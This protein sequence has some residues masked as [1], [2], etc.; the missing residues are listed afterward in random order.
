MDMFM[1]FNFNMIF[2]Y[3]RKKENIILIIKTKIWIVIKKENSIV[4][5]NF[6][7]LLAILIVSNFFCLHDYW[8]TFK[9]Y[10]GHF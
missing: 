3:E 4:K 1:T 2:Y 7:L 8:R 10:L 5:N 9:E 6:D